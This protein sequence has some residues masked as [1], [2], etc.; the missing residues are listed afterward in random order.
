M[1]HVGDKVKLIGRGGFNEFPNTSADVLENFVRACA[2]NSYVN[3]VVRHFAQGHFSTDEEASKTFKVAYIMYKTSVG[4]MRAIIYNAT[5]TFVVAP[6]ALEVVESN[7]QFEVGS[8]VIVADSGHIYSGWGTLI[9]TLKGLISEVDAAQWHENLTPNE[10]DKFKVIYAGAHL[11]RPDETN[12]YVIND[13]RN[14][15]II[16]ER[17]LVPDDPRAKFKPSKWD[18]YMLYLREWSLQNK[19]P[20]GI[21]SDGPLRYGAWLDSGTS[22]INKQPAKR[23]VPAE[24]QKY[25]SYV[26]NWSWEHRHESRPDKRSGP[27][28]YAGWLA[29]C[30]IYRVH[31]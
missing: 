13:G 24:W 28:D 7:I 22:D 18:L 20:S 12:V 15:Y 17:G 30:R 5:N 6:D 19:N 2:N 21:S 10:G 4:G 27:Y 3:G 1:I 25:I 26:L 23:N 29:Y 14:T 16:G 11:S 31:D 8:E 9:E